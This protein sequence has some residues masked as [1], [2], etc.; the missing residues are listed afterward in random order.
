MPGRDFESRIRDLCAKIIAAPEADLAS[1]LSEL[2]GA[3]HEHTVHLRRMAAGN[4]VKKTD[5]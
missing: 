2:R 5:E 4:L 3:L 1:L